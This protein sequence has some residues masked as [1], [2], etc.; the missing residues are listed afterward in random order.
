MPRSANVR[1]DHVC[2]WK[3]RKCRRPQRRCL[4]F[5]SLEV[6][7]LLAGAPRIESFSPDGLVNDPVSAIQMTFDQVIDGATLTAPRTFRSSA[8]TAPSRSNRFKQLNTSPFIASTPSW[9][10]EI[11]SS[12]MAAPFPGNMIP[13]SQAHCPGKMVTNSIRRQSTVSLGHQVGPT[14][15]HPPLRPWTHHCRIH[16][17]TSLPTKRRDAAQFSRCPMLATPFRSK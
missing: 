3:R 2:F 14:T 16:R 10:D 11:F 1:H 12:S 8:P 15:Y 13:V 17:R 7:A 9:M 6:R 4:F 5:E